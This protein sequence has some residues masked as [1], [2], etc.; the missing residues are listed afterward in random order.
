MKQY[1]VIQLARFGDLVQT[2]RL[3]KSLQAEKGSRVHICLD[4]SLE[5]LARLVY[6]EAILH[7]ITAHGTGLD[8]KQASALILTNNRNALLRLAKTDFDEVFN[9]NFSGLNFSLAALF[10][11]HKVRGYRWKNG[12]QIK[13][14]WASMAM[15]WSKNR[16]M[17][18]NIMD[19]WSGYAQK[20]IPPQEVNPSAKPG[21]NGVGVVTAGRESR[22][23][24][25]P[26]LLAAITS[27]IWEKTG[28][29]PMT[30]LGSA[31]EI[32]LPRP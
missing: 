15:R 10:E 31:A 3:V 1:L 27:A 5:A 14:K 16:R 11:P 23:S 13:S 29:G 18:I 7:P 17:G 20:Q 30:V 8:Q 21:G 26:K 22:R 2:K 24:L 28:R 9:L 19:F 6:P 4:H 12:Q 32:K 25:P